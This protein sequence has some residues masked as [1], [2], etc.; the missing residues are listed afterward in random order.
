MKPLHKLARAYRRHQSLTLTA[1]EVQALV[2][3][4]VALESLIDGWESAKS[5]DRITC[6]RRREKPARYLSARNPRGTS[7]LKC[8]RVA[9]CRSKATGTPLCRQCAQLFDGIEPLKPCAT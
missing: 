2:R 5:M 6:E 7:W 1:D 9:T 8:G 3:A 4:D